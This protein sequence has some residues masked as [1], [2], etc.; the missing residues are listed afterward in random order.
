MEGMQD[1]LKDMWRSVV[2]IAPKLAAFIVI[3][4]IG[5]IVAK[6]IGKAVDKILEKVGFDRAVERGGIKTALEQ[7]KYDASTIVGKLVY[8]ALLL[9]VLVLAFGVFG[10][11]PVSDLLTRVVAFLPKLFVAL[12]I[13]VVAAAIAGAVRD[14]LASTLSGLSYGRMLATIASIFILGLGVIAALNQ[15]GVAVTVTLPVLIAVLATIGGIL[16]VGVGGGLIRPMQDRWARY[17]DT[18]EQESRNIRER[19]SGRREQVSG[20]RADD[21]R[22]TGTAYSGASP[23]YPQPSNQPQHAMPPNAGD[24]QQYPYGENQPP[25]PP[26]RP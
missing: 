10:P 25:P 13:I 5:W 3:L 17:L 1:A 23:D 2:A 22:P 18:A 21:V 14:I 8:Y 15:V 9:F 11:N 6:L 7:S 12:I 26:T 20:R 16:V 24:Q 4:V 19:V